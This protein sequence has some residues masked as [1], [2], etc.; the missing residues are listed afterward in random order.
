MPAEA[1]SCVDDDMDYFVSQLINSLALGALLFMM[2]AGLSLIFG[3]MNV[4]N[5][6]HGSFF[7]IG[8]FTAFSVIH[9]TGNFWLALTVGWVPAAAIAAIMERFFIRPMYHTGHLTQV[10][11][12]FGFILVFGD[13]CRLLWGTE[14]LNV[15][16]PTTLSDSL[17]IGSVVV[18]LYRLFIVLS[19]AAMGLALWWFLERSRVGAMVRAGVDDAATAAGIGIN[20]PVLFGAI[21]TLGAAL[22]A[23]GGIIAS[24]VMGIYLGMDV[25]ILIPAFIVIVVGGMG[26]LRG[27]FVGAMLVALIDTFGKAFFPDYALFLVYLLMIVVL[28]IRPQGLFGALKG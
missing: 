21:F 22:A 26:S 8:A 6:A 13:I 12:T 1:F 3:L 18:P 10:L 11:L 17:H 2:S 15:A 5:L 14:I 25:D 4:V 28:L 23:V 9:L 24:P 19:G 27:A 16:P 7:M 20:V